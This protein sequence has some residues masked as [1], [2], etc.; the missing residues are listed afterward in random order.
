MYAIDHGSVAHTGVRL[1]PKKV[2]NKLNARVPHVVLGISVAV[3]HMQTLLV[4][5]NC[6]FFEELPGVL[7]CIVCQE[8]EELCGST[9]FTAT[10]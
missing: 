3:E 5:L 10:N 4:R 1:L 8:T 2:V 9:H 6:V 7:E